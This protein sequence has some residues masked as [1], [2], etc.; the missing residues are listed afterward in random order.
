MT[1]KTKPATVVQTCPRCG[2]KVVGTMKTLY[3]PTEHVEWTPSDHKCI[4]KGK[5]KNE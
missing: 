1:T 4:P 2:L 3:F 5:G